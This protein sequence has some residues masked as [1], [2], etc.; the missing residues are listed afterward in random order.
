MGYYIRLSRIVPDGPPAHREHLRQLLRMLYKTVLQF[1]ML[2]VAYPN[3]DY[4]LETRNAEIIRAEF[5]NSER[6]LVTFESSWLYPRLESALGA[7]PEPN[8]HDTDTSYDYM[9]SS[10]PD[11]E[12][13][14]HPTSSDYAP[15]PS[16]SQSTSPGL[17]YCIHRSAIESRRAGTVSV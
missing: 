17:R 9:M 1:S 2:L 13:L 10:E 4:L 15:T 3:S 16:R 11:S 7:V 6:D 5:A 8:D 14:D 12:T